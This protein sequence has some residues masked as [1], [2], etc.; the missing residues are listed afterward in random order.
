MLRLTHGCGQIQP[1]QFNISRLDIL[2]NQATQQIAK[3]TIDH[4]GL[5][6]NL[7]IV[8]TIEIRSHAHR[9]PKISLEVGQESCVTVK[10]KEGGSPRRRYTSRKNNFSNMNSISRALAQNKV[11]HL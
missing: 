5:T 7:R 2:T 10:K 6:I 4:L 3:G 8:G 1:A 11:C 9:E